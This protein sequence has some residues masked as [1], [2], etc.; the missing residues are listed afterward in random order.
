MPIKPVPNTDQDTKG[1]LLELVEKN[2]QQVSNIETAA[3]KT[4]T[5]S[6][7]V[8]DSIAAF[9]GSMAFVYVHVVFFAVW[10][11]INLWPHLPKFDPAPFSNLTLIVSLEAIFLSTFILISQ[12]RQQKVADHRNHL[13]LQINLLSEQENS[14]IIRM[15]QRI[16][17]R[18][19]IKD[20]LEE[21][22]ALASPTD[23]LAVAAEIEQKI[24]SANVKVDKERLEDQKS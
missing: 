7:V 12:N 4:R 1:L 24:E 21:G 23:L 14:Q 6:D 2:I 3:N 19:E 9:C 16:M 15:M 18:L 17:E 8:A 11:G 13:D 20:G 5:A 10:L 22:A